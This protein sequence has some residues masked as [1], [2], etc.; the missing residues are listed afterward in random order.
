MSERVSAQERSETRQGKK[1][2][3]WGVVLAM[4]F[5]KPITRPKIFP[6]VM[7]ISLILFGPFAV[8]IHGHNSES[9]RR[10]DN[11]EQQERDEKRVKNKDDKVPSATRI[12]VKAGPRFAVQNWLC[13]REQSCGVCVCV[14][15]AR[16]STNHIPNDSENARLGAPDRR[17]LHERV[18]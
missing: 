18:R 16:V 8:D 6:M 1:D 11:E 13:A 3:T 14:C 4:N 15:V 17:Q 5:K 7:R 2:L 10:E 12:A 9:E